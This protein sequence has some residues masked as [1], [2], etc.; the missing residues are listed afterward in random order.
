MEPR[1]FFFWNLTTDSFITNFISLPDKCQSLP[2]IGPCFWFAM[3]SVVPAT[4]DLPY[5]IGDR[6]HEWISSH[7]L[8][9]V[10]EPWECSISSKHTARWCAIISI[11]TSSI[12]GSWTQA[13]RRPHPD[14]SY[15]REGPVNVTTLAVTH[16]SF[17]YSGIKLMQLLHMVLPG[18]SLFSADPP[19]QIR[20]TLSVSSDKQNLP[21]ICFEGERK[22]V[23]NLFWYTY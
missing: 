5:R 2:R 21:S 18:W 20:L 16:M 7:P 14:R 10:H 1:S 8:S 11:R 9:P 22:P 13:V 12:C 3:C 19:S 15:P 17:P 6:D 4:W 23:S